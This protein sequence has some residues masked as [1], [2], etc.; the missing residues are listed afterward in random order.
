MSGE[1][2]IRRGVRNARYAAIPNHV[3]EDT[4]LSMEARWLLSYLLSKP[5]NW[6]VVIGDIIKKGVCGRDKARKMI[7][8]LVDVGYAE[9]EQTR[10]DGKF[11]ASVLVI[12]DEPNVPEV[13]VAHDVSADASESVAFLPQPEMPSPVKPSP[14]LPSPVKS[15]HSNNLNL[16]NTDNQQERDAREAVSDRS[17]LPGTAAFEKRVQRFCSG[18]G[19]AEGEWRGWTSSTLRHIA[20]MFA[21]LSLDERTDA[22]RYR[23]AFLAK[24]NRDKVKPMPVANYFRDKAWQAL[25]DHDVDLARREAERKAGKPDAGKPDGWVKAYSPAHAVEYFRVLLAGPSAPERVPANG[26][27]MT[28]HLMAAWPRLFGFW[29]QSEMRGGLVL[30]NADAALSGLV[31]F[32]PSGSSAF[33]RWR[34]CFRDNGWPPPKTMENGG[35]FPIGGPDGLESFRAAISEGRGDDAA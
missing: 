30:R 12:Y 23:D 35:Y 18:E 13:V 24:C 19:Y 25:S 28:S 21:D 17:D 27:W 33:G 9:R 6:T 2:T 15:A 20:G 32:V 1:A 5:D 11:G 31:E 8:E 16:A 14:V 34:D 3:F 29:K 7:A 10:A 4:R 26:L 22:E